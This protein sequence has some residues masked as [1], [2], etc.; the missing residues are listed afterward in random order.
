MKYS[1]QILQHFNLPHGVG[2]F[3]QTEPD[4][5]TAQVGS[6]NRGDLVQLQLK[7]IDDTIIAAKFKAQASVATIAIC[8]WL[9]EKISGQSIAEAQQLTHLEMMSALQLP[10]VKKHCVVVV[11]EALQKNIL[12]YL[13]TKA[14]VL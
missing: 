13:E 14:I 12:A 3:D 9:I 1:N 7:I 11:L 8:S 6:V 10:S 5:Y 4:I 2:Q